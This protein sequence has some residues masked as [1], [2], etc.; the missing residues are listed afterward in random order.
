MRILP[1]LRRVH[2]PVSVGGAA[3]RFD[4]RRARRRVSSASRIAYHGRTHIVTETLGQTG[5]RTRHT[6]RALF[7]W[8]GWALTLPP[9]WNPVRLEGNYARGYALIDDVHGPR[10]GLRW[11]SVTPTKPFD[12]HAWAKRAMLD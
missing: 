5:T 4:R 11:N 1:A 12:P 10:L 3:V 8:Q 6:T 2:G 9:G 7:A